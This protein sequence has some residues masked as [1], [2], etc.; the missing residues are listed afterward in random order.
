MKVNTMTQQ[1]TQI[2]IEDYIADS[3]LSNSMGGGKAELLIDHPKAVKNLFPEEPEIPSIAHA[4]V[5][6]R[7]RATSWAAR[8]K[9]KKATRNAEIDSNASRGVANLT[10]NLLGNCDELGAIHKYITNV[11]DIHRSMSM[12][13]SDGGER[14]VPTLQYPKW[15]ETMTALQDEFYVLV[16]NFMAVYDWKIMDAQAK[17]G[18]MFNPD[19]YPSASD[20]RAKFSFQLSYDMLA[21]GGNTG[22]WR[23]DLPHEQ[24]SELRDNARDGYFKNIK[25]A[26][27]SIWHRT[28]ETL[29]T[30]VRQLDVNEEGKGNKLYDSVF[31]RAVELVAMMG[32]CNVTGDSQMEA[33]RRKLEDTLHGLNL[34]QIKN[35]PTLRE[36]TRVELT[37]A[38]AAL[39]SL[40]I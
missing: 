25:G 11:R 15:L 31:D 38:I 19:E 35:S 14:L 30:L 9:D 12:T 20:V 2:D 34:D 10:K 29:T 3:Y 1:N 37:A 7:F 40:D 28:Y 8:L 33:M 39:P 26:M 32:T 16:D 22:D 23:L 5:L 17:L 24:M 36:N 4:A 18:D 21:D 27:D 13:W 6:V